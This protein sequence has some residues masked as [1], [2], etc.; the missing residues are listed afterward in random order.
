MR[1]SNMLHFTENHRFYVFR[2]FSLSSLEYKMLTMIYQPMIGGLAISVYHTLYQQLQGDQVGYSPLEQQRRLFFAMDIDPGERGR[3]MFI[4]QA[5]KLEAVG[6]LQTCRKFVSEDEDYLYAYT[7]FRPL[8]PPEFFQNQ[9]LILLLRDKVGKYMLLS[10]RDELLLDEAPELKTANSENISVPFY[11]IFRLNTQT[12]DYELEQVLYESSAARQMERM[13]VVSKGFQFADI[14]MRFPRGSRNRVYVEDLKNR[15]E[16]MISINLV[17]RKYNLTLQETCRLLDEDG[18]FTEEGEL[19]V[20]GLQYKANLYYRQGKKREEERERSISRAAELTVIQ[21]KDRE[22]ETEQ[23][24]QMEYYLAVPQLLQGECNDH[25]Y[26]YILKNEPY[27]FVLKKF[28]PHGSVPDGVMDIF[29]KIDLNYK[30]K[31]EVINVLIHYIYVDRR[32][33]TKASIE[34]VASDMLGKQ[35]LTYEQAVEY[36]RERQRYKEQAAAKAAAAKN[37]GRGGRN[38]RGQTKQQ[39]PQ[40]PIVQPAVQQAELTDEELQRII[41]KARRLDEKFK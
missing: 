11:D 18:M 38:T 30:L 16:H 33:W 32:S 36:V 12:I 4:E 21:G 35:I 19:L 22:G 25:Q 41:Q 23:S 40:I 5:S 24:V 34:A 28:F 3:K 2:D 8:S 13:D 7:L 9:H 31:E 20:D 15:P 26:N 1:I 10:L 29:E 6:L 17:A 14:L 27:T 37:K 39:K